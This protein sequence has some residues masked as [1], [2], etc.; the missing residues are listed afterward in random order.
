MT[1]LSVNVDVPKYEKKITFKAQMACSHNYVYKKRWVGMILI[2]F[3]V[4]KSLKLSKL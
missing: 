3:A 4:K 1:A 2:S